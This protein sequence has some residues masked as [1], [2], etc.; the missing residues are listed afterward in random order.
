MDE[1]AN[2]GLKL[3]GS[4]AAIPASRDFGRM[5]PCS[6]KK[7]IGR[8]RVSG[9]DTGLPVDDVESALR[10]H[11]SSC[12][13]ITDVYIYERDNILMRSGFIYFVGEGAVDKA[14]QLS[15]S[16]VGGWNVSVVPDPFSK[17]SGATL[18]AIGYD[19]SLSDI[20]VQTALT[21]H[22]SSCGE[23][24]VKV[25]RGNTFGSAAAVYITGEDA[26]EKAMER[27]VL[28]MGG[29]KVVAKLLTPPEKSTSHKRPRSG[30]YGRWGWDCRKASARKAKMT[31]E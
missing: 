8:I 2:K 20:D 21:K 10:K 16:D 13:E 31:A 11:F 29:R 24:T 9:Y 12:G 15:G 3:L 22:F 5:K 17:C 26:D 4:D 18:M 27:S 1:S 14:L 6:R 23:V 30:G 28:Y 25:F 19:T 7:E